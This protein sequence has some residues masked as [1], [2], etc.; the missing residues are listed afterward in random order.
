MCM[1]ERKKCHTHE[2]ITKRL[3]LILIDLLACVSSKCFI[4]KFFLY[5]AWLL[6]RSQNKA[7]NSSKSD[8]VFTID[9]VTIE[10]GRHTFAVIFSLKSSNR[11]ILDLT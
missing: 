4:F 3:E 9:D 5:D 8:F 1:R 10:L 2:N 11:Q 7:V 6:I